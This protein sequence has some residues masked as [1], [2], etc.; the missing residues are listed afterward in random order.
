VALV[1]GDLE[2][3]AAQVGRRDD[4]GQRQQRVVGTRRLHGEDVQGRPRQVSR[5]QC[6]EQRRLVH[7]GGARGV[8]EERAGPHLGQLG[9]ADQAPGALVHA[10]V[11]A[12]EVAAAQQ[13]LQ[14]HRLRTDH[15]D[16]LVV[17]P[18]IVYEAARTERSQAYRHLATDGAEPDQADAPASEFVAT[19]RAECAPQAAQVSRGAARL[20][21]EGSGLG[22]AARQQQQ[23]RQ[24]EVCDGGGIA[25]RSVQ[26]GDAQSRT[27]LDVD[28]HGIA[29]TDTDH[30]QVFGAQQR[31]GVEEIDLGDEHVHSPE[32]RDQVRA[33]QQAERVAVPGVLHLSDAAQGLEAI[34]LEVGGGQDART[35]GGGGLRAGRR[36]GR[37][38]PHG[39]G[40]DRCC[41]GRQAAA[42][43]I[44]GDVVRRVEGLRS[45][46]GIVAA[47]VPC[48]RRGSLP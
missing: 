15:A 44:P 6:V 45:G 23:E 3:V 24:G 5:A 31:G 1:C 20:A 8:H 30:L 41:G 22:E 32:S 47:T 12:D 42:P 19:Q 9:G 21:K 34:G 48:Q 40:A 16:L 17:E 11:E 26:H 7:Q 13:R 33:R 2:G 39:Q 14:G 43:G 25:P 28:V 38:G 29:A 4:V 18:R 36:G 37:Q 46:L 10:G 35:E 27:G